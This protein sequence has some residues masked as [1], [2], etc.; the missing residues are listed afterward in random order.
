MGGAGEE[1]GTAGGCPTLGGGSLSTPR[2]RH[3]S[4]RVT[5]ILGAPVASV[6]VDLS[7]PPGEDANSLYLPLGPPLFL[8][9]PSALSRGTQ[10]LAGIKSRPQAPAPPDP[11][12]ET[13]AHV[14][15]EEG[16][17]TLPHL[18]VQEAIRRLFGLAHFSGVRYFYK[19]QFLTIFLVTQGGC[20]SLSCSGRYKHII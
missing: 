5:P 15:G 10:L 12:S 18:S 8:A 20:S 13:G 16:L 11:A 1:D 4:Q 6:N 2:G 19:E 7:L 9:F 17:P 3:F 14:P